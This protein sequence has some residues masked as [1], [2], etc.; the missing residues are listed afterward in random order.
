MP[1]GGKKKEEEKEERKMLLSSITNLNS[2]GVKLIFRKLVAYQGKPEK[3]SEQILG[4][5]KK[6]VM[7]L[8]SYITIFAIF[9]LVQ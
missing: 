5:I 4:W 8:R 2:S 3:K 7:I 6:A 9:L 1:E